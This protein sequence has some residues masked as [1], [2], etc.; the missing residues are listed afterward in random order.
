LGG[1]IEAGDLLAAR[2]C[3]ALYYVTPVDRLELARRLGPDA[4][5]SLDAGAQEAV[6]AL[7]AA[8]FPVLDLHAFL[9]RG[10]MD[11][12]SEHLDAD[13]R[14]SLARRLGAWT[15]LLLRPGGGAARGAD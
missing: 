15:A 4:V 13:G 1:L 8:G 11:L 9:D 6:A 3:R 14:T 7:R 12:P 5:R 10:F 2:G